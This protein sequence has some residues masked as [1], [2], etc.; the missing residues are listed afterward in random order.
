MAFSED[1]IKAEQCRQNRELCSNPPDNVVESRY[2]QT[3]GISIAAS[4][5]EGNN[6]FLVK[7]PDKAVG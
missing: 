2:F 5:K 3:I 1:R 4:R 7:D 6:I